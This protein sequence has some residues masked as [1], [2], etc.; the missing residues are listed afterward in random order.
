MLSDTAPT[1]IAPNETSRATTVRAHINKDSDNKPAAPAEIPPEFAQIITGYLHNHLGACDANYTN[2]LTE[3][4]R[5]VAP[6]ATPDEVY[7]FLTTNLPSIIRNRNLQSKTGIL[8]SRAPAVFSGESLRQL[9]Y[10]LL[11]WREERRAYIRRHPSECA[12]FEHRWAD[13]VQRELTESN[14][15]EDSQPWEGN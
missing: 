9:R 11:K 3:S 4:I 1:V 12:E 10:D 14:P 5:T 7:C 13:K 15:T 2:R 6:D 8:L